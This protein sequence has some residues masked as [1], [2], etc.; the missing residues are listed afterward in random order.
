MKRVPRRYVV[1]AGKQLDDVW[2]LDNADAGAYD[3]WVLGPNGYHRAFAGELTLGH[4]DPEIRVCYD[5]TYGKVL[6]TLMN[7]SDRPCAFYVTAKAYR[8]DGPWTAT[9]AA[10]AQQECSWELQDSGNWYDFEVTCQELPAYYRR[11]SGRVET[12]KDSITDPA[13]GLL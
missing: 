10:G 7:S 1:E 4:A 8:K 6:V 11:F 5:I 2:V 13:M 12:G 9:V 3:L